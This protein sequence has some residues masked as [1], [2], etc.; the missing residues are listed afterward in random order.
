MTI[1]IL[2]A[3]KFLLRGRT[4]LGRTLKYLEMHVLAQERGPIAVQ[5]N[6]DYD[7]SFKIHKYDSL[8]DR[9]KMKTWKIKELFGESDRSELRNVL[10]AILW[11]GAPTAK[12][13]N[14]FKMPAVFDL[15][16]TRNKMFS[17]RS[18]FPSKSKKIA[19][20][21]RANML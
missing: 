18:S 15:R 6:N 11:D 10:D 17:E 21:F 14:D 5:Y 12:L 3:Q 4:F 19:A 2:Y 7:A 16:H 13:G 20:P 9:T 8:C 1:G